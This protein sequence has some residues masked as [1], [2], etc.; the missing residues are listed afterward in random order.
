VP[1]IG[2]YSD[3]GRFGT[4]ASQLA[5]DQIDPGSKGGEEVVIERNS[6]LWRCCERCRKLSEIAAGL[7][8]DSTAVSDADFV[9]NV[10]VP[11]GSQWR[12]W[13]EGR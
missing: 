2:G 8:K 4:S 3:K 9:D 10:E 11:V 7:A 12:G 5:F 13:V 6:N 1:R